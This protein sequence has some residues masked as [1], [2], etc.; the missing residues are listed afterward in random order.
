[1]S[2]VRKLTVAWGASRILYGAALLAAPERVG[3]PWLGEAASQGG[4]RV[5]ARS[6]AVRDGALGLGVAIAAASGSDPRP[7][8]AA[9][10]AGDLVDLVAT[11]IDRD[12]LPER[13]APATVAV[14]GAMAASG[15]A[16][17]AAS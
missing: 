14:A 9:C 11:L 1:M 6:L 15:T 4:G 13:S 7:W 12:G 8:L 2:D 5:A 3:T 17:A 16:L 10:V